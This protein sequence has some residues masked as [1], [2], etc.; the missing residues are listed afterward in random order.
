ML[1]DQRMLGSQECRHLTSKFVL[2]TLLNTI[3]LLLQLPHQR[4][5]ASSFDFLYRFGDFKKLQSISVCCWKFKS[6]HANSYNY[7]YYLFFFGSLGILHFQ[8]FFIGLLACES[9]LLVANIQGNFQL[10]ESP[11]WAVPGCMFA[12]LININHHCQTH[13]QQFP[14]LVNMTRKTQP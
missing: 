14:L 13:Y 2:N 6:S 4:A 11:G 5:L 8:P 9:V 7:L 12:S 1:G 10:A 3:Y